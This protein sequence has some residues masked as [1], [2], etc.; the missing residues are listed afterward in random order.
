[1]NDLPLNDD[2]MCDVWGVGA[3]CN[4]KNEGKRVCLN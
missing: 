4:R 2:P 1:M 3:D